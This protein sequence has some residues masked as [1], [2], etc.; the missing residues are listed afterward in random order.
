MSRIFIS[1]SHRDDAAAIAIGQWL[2]DHGWSDHFLDI[3]PD[4]GLSPGE[5]WQEALKRAA[6]RCEA[7]LF[8]ISDD[9][10]RSKWCLA[11]FLL[12]KQLGKAIFGI[13]VRATPLEQ[14]PGEMRNEWQL[15]DLVTGAERESFRVRIE[16]TGEDVAVSFPSAGLVRL[17]RGIERAGLSPSTFPWPP[18]GDPDRAP[19][20]GLRAMDREDAAVFFGREGPITVALD[21]LRRLRESGAE[22]LFVILGASG[23]GKSSFLRAGLLPRLARDDRNFFVLPVIRPERAGIT[24]PTGL[25]ASLE[26]AFRAVRAPRN[27][28]D[29]RSAVESPDVFARLVADL[30]VAAR[31][32]LGPE[33]NP[34]LVFSIDQAEELF[35]SEHRQEAEQLLTLL[36]RVMTP[37]DPADGSASGTQGVFTLVSIRSDSYERLQTERLMASVRQHV[38]SL[39]PI[40]REEYKSIIEGPAER[41]QAAGN[42]LRVDPRLTT[43]LLVDTQ[44]ADA[45]PLLAFTLERLFVEHG[46]DG[47][48]SLDDYSQLGGVEGSIEAAVKTALADPSADP[49]IPADEAEQH[50]LLRAAFI[51]WLAH[52]DAETE[53]RRRRVAAWDEI[54]AA[55]RGILERLVNQRLLVRDRRRV[56][57]TTV[58]AIVVEVAHEALLRRWPMLTLWLEQ[59]ADALKAI[60]VAKRA[61]AEWAKHGRRDAWLNHAT[62]R[63]TLIE[64]LQQRPDLDRL[65]GEDGRAY[66]RACRKR[67]RDA[68]AEVLAREQ[69]RRANERRI[70]EAEQ[71]AERERLRVAE[72]KSAQATE[73]AAAARR[74]SRRT[75]A[76]AGIAILLMIA[77][78][79]AALSA[80]RQQQAAELALGTLNATEAT[81]KMEAGLVPES[82]AHLA[83]AVR[84]APGEVVW[85]ASLVKAL[86]AHRWGR[87]T[88]DIRT[89]EP[90]TAAVFSPD[91]RRVL[92]VSGDEVRLWDTDTGSRIGRALRHR[93][94][95]RDATFSPDGTLI[96]TASQDRTARVWD[97][98]TGVPRTEPIT[99]PAV[100]TAAALL[101]DGKT[102]LTRA[103]DT[104]R[105]IDLAKPVAAERGADHVSPGGRFT[106]RYDEGQI[107]FWDVRAQ[108][109]VGPALQTIYQQQVAFSSDESFGAIASNRVV[110]IV[111]MATGDFVRATMPEWT[112]D[113]E[114]TPDGRFLLAWGSGRGVVFDSRSG[115]PAGPPFGVRDATDVHIAPG[116]SQVTVR[117]KTDDRTMVRLWDVATG[118]PIVSRAGA[119]LATLCGDVVAIASATDVTLWDVQTGKA[120]GQ[121]IAHAAPIQSMSFSA[122]CKAGLSV[123][124]REVRVWDPATARPIAQP[125][126]HS[127]HVTTATFSPDGRRVASASSDGACVWDLRAGEA[128]GEPLR[129]PDAYDHIAFGA[130][131]QRVAT[132]SRRQVQTWNAQTGAPVGAPI[133]AG[134]DVTSIAISP[135]GER[136]LVETYESGTVYRHDEWRPRRKAVARQLAIRLHVGEYH[137]EPRLEHAGDVRWQDGAHLARRFRATSRQAPRAPAAHHAGR[138]QPRRFADRDRV[139]RR[140]R[141]GVGGGNRQS[142]R[143]ADAARAGG[144]AGHLQWKRL[145]RRDGVRQ[146]VERRKPE[147]ALPARGARL[148]R[149][150]R[151]V[152][153]RGD[154][155]RRGCHRRRD[156]P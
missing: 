44:G 98:E 101:N 13:L 148:E 155:P 137:D 39:P 144:E 102:L 64:S 154:F 113:L 76:G 92:V 129:H 78:I 54:P 15:C 48:L 118:Q 89:P 74:L 66:V 146:A 42:R 32:R 3:S 12:A 143:C 131:G 87:I 132:V 65:L 4:R 6:D 122:G 30:H 152:G 75:M 136:V 45:L 117:S 100:V 88:A 135:N 11:E 38:F 128:G 1:H 116:G 16:A 20:S 138:L 141:T 56:P 35:A 37:L 17:R 22:R 149:P 115:S 133:S 134:T 105:L 142:R 86:I 153:R 58:D 111:D 33:A 77:A 97:A 114:F 90:A 96:V 9:W 19:Y 150:D 107:Q 68:E 120:I 36:R 91:G 73:R 50:Q 49:A 82:V 10:L 110:Q 85:R 18:P 99:H 53:E 71:E 21:T 25:L 83:E 52:V 47:D 80:R 95:V 104:Q 62:E 123:A 151:R 43:Q 60:D 109:P 59:D 121:P 27:R 46:A 108:R 126:I 24:G 61:A 94:I 31:A 106:A 69:E 145:A 57:G 28:A 34:V 147:R 93:N 8:L 63:L 23:S 119:H 67:E 127:A 84:L 70:Q 81:R 40:P 14:L 7:V 51:P 26:A 79:V 55:S 112:T 139:G 72:A 125:L 2:T 124:G 103:G 130:G 41:H 156:Q 140:H 5:R 29:L